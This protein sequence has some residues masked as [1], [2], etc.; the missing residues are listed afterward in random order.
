MEWKGIE[1]FRGAIFIA[2]VLDLPASLYYVH[3]FHMLHVIFC[4]I[5][6]INNVAKC[7]DLTGKYNKIK[8]NKDEIQQR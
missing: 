2:A 3:A 5:D 7:T 8:F 1:P 6:E 4:L